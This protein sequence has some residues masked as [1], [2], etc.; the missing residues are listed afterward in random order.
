MINRRLVRKKSVFLVMGKLFP[1]AL[2]VLMAYLGSLAISTL[3]EALL[4]YMGGNLPD[5]ETLLYSG[6]D[7]E[8]MAL[9]MASDNLMKLGLMLLL[10]GAVTFLLVTPLTFG[11]LRWYLSLAGDTPQSIG[12]AL[13]PYSSLKTYFSALWLYLY[14]ALRKL[15]WGIPIFIIPA[16]I[17]GAAVYFSGDEAYALLSVLLLFIGM[18]VLFA[19]YALFVIVT[20]R[21][22]MT[23][24]IYAKHDGIK[25]TEA[26]SISVKVM[27]PYIYNLLVLQLSLIPFV[28]IGQFVCAGALFI[29]PFV[30]TCYAVYATEL[31]NKEAAQMPGDV[32]HVDYKI[33]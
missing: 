15:L 13:S 4:T 9:F 7:E 28:I 21:Y 12:Y 33:V 32:T 1:A 25:V 22:F 3:C 29:L 27:K 5:M 31:M 10:Y 8:S 24:Y 14:T 18:S 30:N 19:A 17:I 6:I 2:L 16:A 20:N 23:Q 26:L 11:T